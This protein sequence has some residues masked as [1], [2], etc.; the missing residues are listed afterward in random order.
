MFPGPAL[1][2]LPFTF[3]TI[4]THARSTHDRSSCRDS[5]TVS[6]FRRYDT[7]GWYGARSSDAWTCSH[8]ATTGGRIVAR[9]VVLFR[10]VG[11]IILFINDVS[12]KIF[13][14]GRIFL[15]EQYL[16]TPIVFYDAFFKFLF[17]I[18]SCWIVCRILNDS[19]QLWPLQHYEIKT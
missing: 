16:S 8:R 17:W 7:R 2:L 1:F 3:S 14:S 5:F 10:A 18:P 11:I 4:S 15:V 6:S 9:I 12:K 13:Y 19:R